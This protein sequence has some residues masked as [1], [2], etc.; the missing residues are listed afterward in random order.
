MFSC[1]HWL[2]LPAAAAGHRCLCTRVAVSGHSVPG[3]SA[4][5]QA[6]QGAWPGA[7]APGRLRFQAVVL[8]RTLLLR[9]SLSHA[10]SV[11]A[12]TH[13]ALRTM[14]RHAAGTQALQRFHESNVLAAKISEV[15]RPKVGG[16]G[17]N[18]LG[19]CPHPPSGQLVLEHACVRV[20]R[21]FFSAVLYA[22]LQENEMSAAACVEAMC[23]F[24]DGLLV[25]V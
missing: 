1:W 4:H 20:T 8:S 17:T 12:C 21:F 16:A 18:T 11:L 24:T 10:D 13:S 23:T 22:C 14:L 6:P 19:C 7:R 15:F 2:P 3:A 5:A 9:A 25:F